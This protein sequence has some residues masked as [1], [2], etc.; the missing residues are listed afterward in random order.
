MLLIKIL[1]KS[2]FTRKPQK[3][4]KTAATRSIFAGIYLDHFHHK[5]EV[6]C[7]HLSP[8]T[9]IWDDFWGSSAHFSVFQ[10]LQK[11]WVFKIF[12]YNAHTFFSKAAPW[13]CVL[14]PPGPNEPPPTHPK[15]YGNDFDSLPSNTRL[16]LKWEIETQTYRKSSRRE[17]TFRWSRNWTIGTKCYWTAN[18]V[19]RRKSNYR[20]R[21]FQTITIITPSFPWVTSHQVQFENLSLTR[22]FLFWTAGR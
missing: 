12:R 14:D 5:L 10:K 22:E 6:K 2:H 3:R 11:I 17:V 1:R 21:D 16:L 13:H 15:K 4:S 9:S 20:K 7:F 19:R 8:R 18:D